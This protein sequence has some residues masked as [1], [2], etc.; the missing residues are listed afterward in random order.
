MASWALA[1]AKSKFSEVVDRAVNHEP[2]E[3]TR[4][5]K[6]IAV[7]VSRDEWLRSKRKVENNHRS[8]AEFFRNS[9]LRNS[10]IDLRRSKSPAR[11]VDL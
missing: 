6:P 8:M 4:N 9:P 7:L 10:G 5:G 2:Q 11:K 1:E 3:I